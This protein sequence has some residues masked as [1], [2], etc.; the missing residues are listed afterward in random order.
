MSANKPPRLAAM[1]VLPTPPLVLTK[2]NLITG[3]PLPP[4][5]SQRYLRTACRKCRTRAIYFLSRAPTDR[6]ANPYVREGSGC[7]RPMQQHCFAGWE[8]AAPNVAADE[9][10]P[11]LGMCL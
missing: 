11:P 3:R 4:H 9:A 1:V 2:A 10:G 7:R 6:E 5:G 8:L